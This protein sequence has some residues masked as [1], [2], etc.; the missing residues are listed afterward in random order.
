MKGIVVGGM[1]FSSEDPFPAPV[2]AVDYAD[3]EEAKIAAKLLSTL[4]NGI[5]PLN[6]GQ[7]KPV[8]MGDTNVKI[9]FLGMGPGSDVLC[10][11]AA[12]HDPR[13]LT[14]GLYAADIVTMDQVK[15]FRRLLEMHNSYTF[16]VS[17]NEQVMTRELDVVKYVVTE[18]G[19]PS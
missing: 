12:K 6:M 10:E 4:Q 11:V 15:A 13:H 8:F 14:F 17:C 7:A 18:R 9:S 3:E 2:I 16:T 5:C 1:Q 19:V